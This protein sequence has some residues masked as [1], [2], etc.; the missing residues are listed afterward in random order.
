M[1]HMHK[2][3]NSIP[4]TRQKKETWFSVGCVATHQYAQKIMSL[5][6]AW[7]IQRN[8]VPP[9]IYVYT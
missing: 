5:K 9:K 3:L 8:P 6:P 4:N 1:P 7:A 2:A